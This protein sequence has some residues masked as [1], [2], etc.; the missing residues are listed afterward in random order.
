MFCLNLFS[1]SQFWK[2]EFL[3]WNSTEF[4]GIKRVFLP[5]AKHWKPDLVLYNK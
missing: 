5:T 3:T 4:D 2:D 1:V